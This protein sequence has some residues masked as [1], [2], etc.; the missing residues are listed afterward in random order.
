[1]A[2]AAVAPPLG[3]DFD[4]WPPAAGRLNLLTWRFLHDHAAKMPA[5]ARPSH[6]K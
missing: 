1:V 4:G 6:Q 5:R 3:A 2:A